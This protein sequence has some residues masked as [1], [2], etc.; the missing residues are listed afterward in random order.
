MRTPKPIQD[1]NNVEKQELIRVEARK[2]LEKEQELKKI[3]K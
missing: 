1:N 2:R 3:K